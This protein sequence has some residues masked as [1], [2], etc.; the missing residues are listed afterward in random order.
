MNIFSKLR[1]RP[2]LNFIPHFK[3]HVMKILVCISKTP[4][5]TA[6]IAFTNNNTKFAGDG[7]QW[8]INPYDEWYALV[9]AIEL[10]EKDPSTVLHLV[11][12]GG[13]DMD[14]IIRKALA[15]GGDEAIRVNDEPTDPYVIAVQIAQVARQGGYDLIFTGKETIDYNGSAIGGM[16]AELL[17]LPYISLATKFEL[18]GT[19]ATVT[20][21]IE[22]GEETDEVS[23]PLVVSCQK[24]VAEQRIPNMKGIMSAR[25][26]PLKVVEPV[27]TGALTHIVSFELPPAKAGVKLVPADNPAELI[28]LLHE[29]ARVF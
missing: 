11:S 22:G 14:P 3:I 26:K 25:T 17:D 28:S 23:L 12:V 2:S 4:D 29:E 1:P 6:K 15:I 21:E 27:A 5:T 20:R 13:P 19:T 16:V 18:S 8:I 7:V 9:R 24:G 10:K